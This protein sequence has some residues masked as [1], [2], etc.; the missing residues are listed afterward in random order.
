MK[1]S[2][3]RLGIIVGVIAL[4]VWGF[5]PPEQKINL[6]LDLK[7]GVHLVLRVHSD[8]ALRLETET[9]TDRLRDTLTRGGVQ[10]SKLEATTPQEFRVEGVSNPA[11]L[12]DA[13][14]DLS[15]LYDRNDGA[16]VTTFRLKPNVA[17]QLRADAVTQALQT[18]ER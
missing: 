6:G 9:T 14:A 4:A 17:N 3:V 8:D 11:A 18:I 16:G 10:F 5:Y 12:N 2:T 7:G 15:T 1:N 13:V